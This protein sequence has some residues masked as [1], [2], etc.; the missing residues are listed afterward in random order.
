MRELHRRL[1]A[2]GAL[3]AFEA[4]GRHLNFSR[5]A[6]ELCVTQAAVSRAIRGL[7]EQ[8]GIRLFERLHRSVALTAAGASLHQAVAYGFDHI[9]D[10]VEQQRARQRERHVGVAANNAVAFYWLRPQVT[11]FQQAHPDVHLSVFAADPDPPLEQSDVDIAIRYGDGHWPGATL[12]FGEELFPVCAPAFCETAAG[13]IE[14]PEDLL[15]T[16]LLYMDPQGPDWVTWGEWIR[17]QGVDPA[18]CLSAGLTFNS[19]PMLLQAAVEGQG[20]ALGT[21]HLVDPLL[22]D[23]TLVRPM[24]ESYRTSRGYYLVL[25]VGAVPSAIVAAVGD[26]LRDHARRSE[27][28]SSA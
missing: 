19:Y 7:E 1:P 28:S 5:A 20:V 16:T 3:V 9:A 12:L 25:P 4:A 15:R 14:R 6:E 10:A 2:L 21:A 22:A 24:R 17:A 23:G 27:A 18:G 8:L 13:R 11:A 26:W